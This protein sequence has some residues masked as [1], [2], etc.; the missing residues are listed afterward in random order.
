MEIYF[1][2]SNSMPYTHDQVSKL[3]L[4]VSCNFVVEILDKKH[5]QAYNS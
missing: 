3:H 5:K 4:N 2:V 1:S